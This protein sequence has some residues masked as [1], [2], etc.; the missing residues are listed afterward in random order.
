MSLILLLSCS[1]ELTPASSQPSE[2]ANPRPWWGVVSE[3]LEASQHAF[4]PDGVGFSAQ[5]GRHAFS[6]HFDGEGVEFVDAAADA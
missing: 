2:A 5:N 1:P 6:A 4:V 3:R